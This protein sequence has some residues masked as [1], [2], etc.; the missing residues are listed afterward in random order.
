MSEV[1]KVCF[2]GT[3]I[4]NSRRE[5]AQSRDFGL[6]AHEKQTRDPE[7]ENFAHSRHRFFNR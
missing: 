6:L 1:L 3:E 5:F 4:G 7:V 2:V